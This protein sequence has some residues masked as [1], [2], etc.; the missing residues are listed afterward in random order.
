MACPSDIRHELGC[1]RGSHGLDA[2]CETRNLTACRLG[3]NIALLGRAHQNRLC[4]L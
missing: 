1:G 3:M 4:G 2:G